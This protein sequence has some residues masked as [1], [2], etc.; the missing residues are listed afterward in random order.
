MARK[1]TVK[2]HK[3]PKHFISWGAGLQSTALGVL[4]VL[5]KVKKMDGII[6]ADPGWEH[7]YTYKI[8]EFYTEWFNNNNLPVEI[9]TI[10]RSIKDFEW[11]DSPPFFYYNKAPI[12]R[13]CTRYYK[14]DPIRTA[15]RRLSGLSIKNTGRTLKKSCYCYMGITYDEATRMRDSN[16]DWLVYEYPLVDMKWTRESCIDMFNELGLP[17]PMKS[18]CMICPYHRKKDWALIK[19]T[20]PDEWA[21]ILKFDERIRNGSDRMRKRDKDAKC[22]LYNKAIPLS[23]VDFSMI[24]VEKDISDIC[25][26]GYCFI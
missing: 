13:Q 9:V 20:Y 1:Y 4:S 16:R 6:F 8:I 19:D 14:I 18:S 17:I 25:D 10:G 15:M 26:E 21:E 24:D 2:E 22:Y 11:E 5:G 23:E 12:T 7:P 3:N